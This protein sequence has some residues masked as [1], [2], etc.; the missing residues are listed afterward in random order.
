[1][2]RRPWRKMRFLPF[3]EVSPKLG[4]VTGFIS[5]ASQFV[6]Y[7]PPPWLVTRLSRASL[8]RVFV[9]TSSFTTPV[10]KKP[11]SSEAPVTGNILVGE[12]IASLSFSLSVLFLSFPL[13]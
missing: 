11:R 13:I 9:D 10:A 4:I 8:K 3:G 7:T 1:M 6:E 5:D 12:R 2:L